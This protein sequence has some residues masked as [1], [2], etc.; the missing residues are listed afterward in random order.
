MEAY[1]RIYI[2]M[3]AKNKAII[4]DIIDTINEGGTEEEITEL[5][6]LLSYYESEYNAAKVALNNIEEELA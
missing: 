1:K 2:D 4:D 5:R 3:I 6:A